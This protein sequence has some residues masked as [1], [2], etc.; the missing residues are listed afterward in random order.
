VG[1]DHRSQA[2]SHTKGLTKPVEW[3][4][5]YLDLDDVERDID[6]MVVALRLDRAGLFRIANQWRSVLDLLTVSY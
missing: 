4:Q 5:I 2:A 3:F 6:M 1:L